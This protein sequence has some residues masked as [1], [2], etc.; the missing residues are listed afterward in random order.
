MRKGP[1]DVPAS[2]LLLAATL[3]GQILL[4]MLLF[5]IPSAEAQ[6]TPKVLVLIELGLWMLG[7][8]LVLRAA[9]RPERFTQTMTAI[10]G[11]QLVIAPLTYA[12]RWLLIT[13][14]KDPVLQT[15]AL[16]F[17]AVLAVWVLV[18]SGRILRS[19][20][21]WSLFACIFLVIAIQVFIVL[22]AF[23]IYT[24]PPTGAAVPA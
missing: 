15:P 17:T 6:D 21:G 8:M 12:A 9:G 7:V 14:Q 19:A 20:T 1:E 2:T 11:C 23:T 5:A 22:V 24:P 18:V 10:F 3:A 16:F 4:G 13:Y